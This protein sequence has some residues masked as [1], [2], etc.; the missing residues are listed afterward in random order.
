MKNL[1]IGFADILVNVN[2]N[3][4]TNNQFLKN[5][6]EYL[7]SKKINLYLVTGL[8]EDLASKLISQNKLGSYFKKENIISVTNE[9]LNSFSEI[10]KE[11]KLSKY[12]DNPKYVDEYLK[13]DF[14]IKQK[15]E[16]NNP[17]TLFI[18]R[19]IWFDAYYVSKYT[20]AH[21]VLL[22]DILTYNNKPHNKNL[23]TINL[24]GSK[25]KDFK[26]FLESENKFDYF[27]LHAFANNVLYKKAVGSLDFSKIDLNKLIKKK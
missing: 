4:K 6:S 2:F 19:D 16:L 26:N 20:N 15:P 3:F 11:L 5:L 13:I 1:V 18:G 24:I 17:E 22:K 21:V 14:I 7:D 9:Y 25:F 12:K 10:D 8:K 23:N 27:A